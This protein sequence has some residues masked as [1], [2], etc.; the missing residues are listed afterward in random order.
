M[1]KPKQAIRKFIKLAF[2]TA[3]LA[4]S[5]PSSALAL[6]F[7]KIDGVQ[8]SA[9]V[10]GHEHDFE[11]TSYSWE[12][13]NGGPAGTGGA[14]TGR[15]VMDSF[16]FSMRSGNGSPAL[17][18]LAA[19]GTHL[20]QAILSCSG[21]NLNGERIEN[22]RWTLGDST[23]ISYQ[24][25]LTPGQNN[26]EP[27]DQVTISFSKIVYEYV[28][29]MIKVEW[30]VRENRGGFVSGAPVSQQPSSQTPQQA[31]TSGQQSTTQPAATPK[32]QP[33]AMPRLMR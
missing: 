8:G 30:D 31:S 12:E 5:V 10:R 32:Q 6:C 20:S 1:Q 28:P 11:V 3:C 7:L 13:K 22:F 21:S 18:L 9:T 24:S 15:P 33:L 23:I 25:G 14:N 4:A 29:G 16:R 17:M 2:I 26:S 27:M 19:N